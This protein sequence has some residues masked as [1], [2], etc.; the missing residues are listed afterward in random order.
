MDLSAYHLQKKDTALSDPD[1][2][3][4]I[5]QR[6]RYATIALCREDQPYLVTMNYGL[7]RNGPALYFHSAHKGLK[8]DIIRINPAACATVIE[9][10]GY[11]EGECAHGY[12][13]LILTGRLELVTDPTE[14][15]H[16]LE[17]LLSHQE[18]DPEPWRKKHLQSDEVFRR[19]AILKFSIEQM[20]GKEG[21]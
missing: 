6:N 14:M 12:R 19:T 1:L 17:V 13:S 4:D 3:M 5:L 20:F 16:G 18:N 2:L 8:L 21:D 9:D 15:K 7:D 11:K 10:Q